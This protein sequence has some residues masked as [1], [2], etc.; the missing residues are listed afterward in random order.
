MPNY[1]HNVLESFQINRLENRQSRDQEPTVWRV[2]RIW[3]STISI[4]L[5]NSRRDK[6]KRRIWR[7]PVTVVNDPTKDIINLSIFSFYNCYFFQ[8]RF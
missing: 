3:L 7:L 6:S 5:S 4:W 8:S 1:I 2:R